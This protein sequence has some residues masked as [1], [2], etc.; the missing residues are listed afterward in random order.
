MAGVVVIVELWGIG[1][2][3]LHGELRE[4]EAATVDPSIFLA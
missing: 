1:W 2:L 4:L 3:D